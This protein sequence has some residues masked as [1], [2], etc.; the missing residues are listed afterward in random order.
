MARSDREADSVF[1]RV[2]GEGG[3]METQ[4]GEVVLS[5]SRRPDVYL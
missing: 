4:A 5:S 2:G 3:H 1:K